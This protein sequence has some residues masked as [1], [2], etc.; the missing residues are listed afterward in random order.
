M[1]LFRMLASAT[2]VSAAAITLVAAPAS[3]DPLQNSGDFKVAGVNIRSGPGTGYTVL[4]SGYPGQYAYLSCGQAVSGWEWIEVQNVA[5]G[6][7]G[8][9]KND[10]MYA[11]CS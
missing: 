6:V 3:A 4:G 9:A 7:R 2:V 1:S 8:W 5:T 11:Y 10:L